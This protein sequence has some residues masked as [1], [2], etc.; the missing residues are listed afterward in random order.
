MGIGKVPL[1]DF[2]T[3]T[4]F[5]NSEWKFHNDMSPIFK[6]AIKYAKF[7]FFNFGLRDY[8]DFYENL[9]ILPYWDT[10]NRENFSSKYLPLEQSKKILYKLLIWQNHDSNCMTDIE[11]LD[12]SASI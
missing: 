10:T 11:T 3:T 1:Q 4:D 6:N 7:R 9:E 8:R 12:Q 2:I 5:L